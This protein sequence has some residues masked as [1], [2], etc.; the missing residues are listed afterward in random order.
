MDR[1]YLIH[2]V[3]DMLTTTVMLAR[4]LRAER[5]FLASQSGADLSSQSLSRDKARNCPM[6]LQLLPNLYIFVGIVFLTDSRN[7]AAHE[8]DI[9]SS[10]I[11]LNFSTVWI[12]YY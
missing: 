6:L 2:A 10:S 4:P 11:V 1:G 7:L 5:H 8:R 9:L 3:E 12:I